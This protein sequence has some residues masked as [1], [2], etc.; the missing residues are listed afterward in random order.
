MSYQYISIDHQTFV[1]A[2]TCSMEPDAYLSWSIET[3]SVQDLFKAGWR[4]CATTPSHVILELQVQ[5]SDA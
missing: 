2:T 3:Q 4:V 1:N 5:S